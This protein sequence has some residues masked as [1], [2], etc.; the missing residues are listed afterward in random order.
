M[1]DRPQPNRLLE[2]EQR[3]ALFSGHARRL[4]AGVFFYGAALGESSFSR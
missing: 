4:S 3:R 1:K 2:L